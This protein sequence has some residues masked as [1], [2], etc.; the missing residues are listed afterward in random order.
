MLAPVQVEH[1]RRHDRLRALGTVTT[2]PLPLPERAADAKAIALVHMGADGLG[3][4]FPR[5][6]GVPACLPALAVDGEP[7]VADVWL[8]L[9]SPVP[10]RL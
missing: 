10:T 5:R 1:P 2:G 6:H 9:P 4:V 3:E 7:D 8:Q